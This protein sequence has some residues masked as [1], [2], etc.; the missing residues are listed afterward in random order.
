MTRTELIKGANDF[1]RLG[2]ATRYPLYKCNV[3]IYEVVPKKCYIL[4]SYQTIVAVADCWTAYHKIYVFDYYSSTTN[5]THISRFAKWLKH[6]TPFGWQEI[7]PL[8][9]TSRMSK[10]AYETYSKNDWAGVISDHI[11]YKD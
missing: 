10:R 9:K 11:G 3:C 5:A 1:N 6:E 8:Y 7:I 4:R 2:S